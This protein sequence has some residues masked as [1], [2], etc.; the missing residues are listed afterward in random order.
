M[1]KKREERK[2]EKREKKQVRILLV[3][4]ATIFL[5]SISTATAQVI[6]PEPV[7]PQTQWQAPAMHFYPYYAEDPST[8]YGFEPEMCN[9]SG[10]DFIVQIAPD[11]CT[12]APVRSD[13]LEE[14]NVPVFCRLTGIKINP[15]IQVPYIERIDA[16]TEQRSDEIFSI[17][18]HPPKSSLSFMSYQAPN[19]N[20]LEGVPTMTNLGYLVIF[21][22]QQPQE[23]KMPDSVKIEE[24][25]KL[26]Y[27]VART[28]G[29]NQNTIVLK[30]DTNEE[31]QENY[32][33]YSFWDGKGYLKLDSIQN[34]KAKI[35]VYKNTKQLIGSTTLNEGDI[36]KEIKLPGFYC[37]AGVQ[38]RVDE[39]TT[40]KTRARLLV[41]GQED[42]VGEG[43]EILD[44]GCRVNK[45]YPSTTPY[46]GT[47]KISCPKKSA[48][49]ELKPLK[50][51]FKVDGQSDVEKSFGDYILDN[52]KYKYIGYI[53]RNKKQG[54]EGIQSYVIIF[55]QD[56]TNKISAGDKNKIINL[57]SDVIENKKEGSEDKNIDSDIVTEIK[58]ALKN[59]NRF[60]AINVEFKIKSDK[61][62]D[63][64]LDS[65]TGLIDVSYSDSIE[66]EFTEAIEAYDA[67]SES[68][69]LVPTEDGTIYGV[70][71][72]KAAAD[73]AEIFNKKETQAEYLDKIIRD[74]SDVEA[75]VAGTIDDARKDLA[76]LLS[77]DPAKSTAVLPTK[78]GD[79]RF[80]LLAIEQPGEGSQKLIIDVD[81][82]DKSYSLYDTIDDWR[83]EEIKENF[84]KLRCIITN[85]GTEQDKISYG[86]ERTL[87]KGNSFITRDSTLKIIE[88]ELI[89]EVK[90]TVLPFESRRTTE[91]NFT[92]QIGIEKR[93]IQLN[94]EKTNER[95]E[96]LN[97]LISK[98]EGVKNSLGKVINVWKKACLVGGTALWAKNFLQ[99][100]DG[101]SLARKEVMQYYG[102]WC[103]DEQHRISVGADTISG[104]YKA[105]QQDIN[106]DVEKTKE[107]INLAN[108][109]IKEVK[110]KDGVVK[111]KGFL[112]LG[113]A[114]DEERFFEE[115]NILI[116][117]SKYNE[118]RNI[119]IDKDGNQVEVNSV[120]DLQA[121]KEN[122]GTE[123]V[124]DIIHS[125][126]LQKTCQ[127][128]QATV[129]ICEKINIKNY[130]QF[131][132]YKSLIKESNTRNA[133]E[134]LGLPYIPIVR[135]QG[136][137]ID[138]P[139]IQKISELKQQEK[140]G[141][142]KNEFGD[143]EIVWISGEGFNIVAS[144]K[145]VGQGGYIIEKAIPVE[146]RN[147]N[148]VNIKNDLTTEEKTR[149]DNLV[150]SQ[151][152]SIRLVDESKCTNNPIATSSQEIRFWESGEYKGMVALMPIDAARGYYV[153]IKSYSGFEGGLVAYGE[154]S[155]NINT[156][157]IGNV[158]PDKK[159]DFDFSTGLA[160]IG[161]DDCADV[162]SL[163]Q[164]A[165][166]H[167][168]G[169]SNPSAINDKAKKC[170]QEAV[171]QYAQGKREIKTSCGTFKVGKSAT[172]APTS[173]CEDFMSP[174]DCWIMY[175]LCDPVMCPSSRCDLG[176]RYPVD[177]VA[178]TGII[179]S[180]MLC[181]PN[182]ENGKGVLV[183]ICLDGLHAGLENLEVT[184][185]LTR[186]CL[187]ENINTGKMT[188]ICDQIL[189]IYLCD[190]LWQ[191]L[192]PLIKVGLPSLTE[193]LT[194]RGGGEYALFP[195][196]WK[197]SVDS[198]EYFT[199]YYG[200]STFTAFKE[201][202]TAQIGT[203]VC[204]RFMSVAYP[205][206]TK[207]WEEI[208][209]PES[210]T[211]FFA[212]F[213]ELE[214]IAA[215]QAHYKVYYQIYAGQD[216]GVAYRVYLKSPSDPG[217]Y[218]TPERYYVPNA[219]GYLA[220]GE[221]TAASPDF[222][223]PQ[224]YKEVCVDIN[225]QENCG[226]T[227]VTSN[228]AIDELQS[229]YVEQQLEA[230]VTK[231]KDCISGAPTFIPTA[232]LN[233]QSAVQ[234]T[235]EPAIYR[236]GI[237]RICASQ[238][239]GAGVDEDRYKLVGYC[240]NP[241]IGCYLD[242]D[243][244][245]NS[246][247]DL[248]IQEDI[249]T[250][251]ESKEINSLMEIEGL[252]H[253][254]ISRDE[255]TKAED[256]INK[257]GG[258][259]EIVEFL[260]QQVRQDFEKNGKAEARTNE[261]IEIAVKDI[262]SLINSF[263]EISAGCIY[264]SEKARADFNI[265]LLKEFKARL[266]GT[267]AIA[268]GEE[269][270]K[271][272]AEPT[273]EAEVTQPTEE[274]G[275][276]TV[277]P[278]DFYDGIKPCYSPKYHEIVI[279]KPA[280]GGK[281]GE[282]GGGNIRFDLRAIAG[283]EI[284]EK[285]LITPGSGSPTDY[286][287]M[288]I[289]IKHHDTFYSSYYGFFIPKFKVGDFVKEG[290][291]F[292]SVDTA[293][294]FAVYQENP[295]YMRTTKKE[296][297]A[298]NPF[299]YFSD[300]VL[301]QIKQC[302]DDIEE[303]EKYKIISGPFDQW[304]LDINKYYIL[305]SRGCYGYRSLSWVGKDYTDGIDISAPGGAEVYAV[306]SGEVFYIS[307][308]C[309]R[310]DLSS[311]GNCK[312]GNCA[313]N[314]GYGNSVIIKHSDNLFTA[315]NHLSN[316]DVKKGDKINT[317]QKL[318]TVGSTGCSSDNHLDFKVYTSQQE[319]YIYVGDKGKHPLCFFSSE[320]KNKIDYTTSGALTDSKSYVENKNLFGTEDGGCNPS[321]E[322][323]SKFI[324]FE[325]EKTE[326]SKYNS[327]NCENYVGC[328]YDYSWEKC[329]ECPSKCEGETR[330]LGVF[331]FVG[332][333]FTGTPVNANDII[334]KTQDDC[335]NNNCDLPYCLWNEEDEK[336][337][338]LSPQEKLSK[339]IR[340]FSKEID[341][342][343][344]IGGKLYEIKNLISNIDILP[345]EKYEE[346]KVVLESLKQKTIDI[347]NFAEEEK[348][349]SIQYN[350]Y[351]EM[352]DWK[353]KIENALDYISEKETQVILVSSIKGSYDSK[354]KIIENNDASKVCAVFVKGDDWFNDELAGEQ[355]EGKTIQAL[356]AS[357]SATITWYKIEPY[358][359]HYDAGFRADFPT[360][361]GE[362]NYHGYQNTQ[363]SVYWSEGKDTIQYKN[364]PLDKTTWCINVGSNYGVY[365][366]RTEIVASEGTYSSPG[367]PASEENELGGYASIYQNHLNTLIEPSAYNFEEGGIKDS[368]HTIARRSD[369][370]DEHSSYRN[371]YGT[372]TK[373]MQFLEYVD[374]HQGAVWIY[375]ENPWQASN[376]IGMD[377][378]NL[379]TNSI[380]KM[381]E[382]G[383]I[384][385]TFCNDLDK[386]TADYLAQNYGD[387]NKVYY[388]TSEDRKIY[389]SISET[390]VEIPT[391][392]LAISSA[393]E[394]FH[395]GDIFLLARGNTNADKCYHTM[396][397]YEDDGDGILDD[398][399]M[400]VYI[401]RKG[402]TKKAYFKDIEEIT[403]EESVYFRV[404]R[405]NELSN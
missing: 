103:A 283:G 111:S 213:D 246:I 164:G 142:L 208:S 349:Y 175:N 328:W 184:L 376:F 215:S 265:A 83:I 140:L 362:S 145:D 229:L 392:D 8:Q 306:A 80:T 261:A 259:K 380:D 294:T 199:Q 289:T 151:I 53:G 307:E 231:T 318:G 296:V 48:D 85:C 239:P 163:Q 248:G 312:T 251:A 81:G 253:P 75:N 323:C 373:Q 40:P 390:I 17:T 107:A 132:Y 38:L 76:R 368:V 257:K 146:E 388:Y 358:A 20:Q 211:Q 370:L 67:I 50:A 292:A 372:T 290:E 223:A 114:I 171:Q 44:S 127:E 25:L 55:Y 63:H 225:G 143:K 109:F 13:L 71:A 6:L 241:N 160:K 190:F 285:E 27:N 113:K 235:I 182:F 287:E 396:I 299:C 330:G 183:P 100:L 310:C 95:I 347:I 97:K 18:Y 136:A 314:N 291:V 93:A 147:G 84:I 212:T 194:S 39:I 130:D 218:I 9:K 78:N 10:M 230:K 167:V 242:M 98:I 202:S 335:E 196:A 19:Q 250:E 276:L 275:T 209:K 49:L 65:T 206:Q 234:S 400:F 352:L 166:I 45:I 21:L 326:C 311:S 82:E 198:F 41:N 315:Y 385:C 319:L 258:I 357:T 68:Y 340:D 247:K 106:K 23:S 133:A 324:T 173:Q 304:P 295:M 74:Y 30:Q 188:G 28:F 33:K 197:N 165:D 219:Y 200:K 94:P 138:V 205:T 99:G 371:K 377:C 5:A 398:E 128:E 369:Y 367:K 286:K 42:L 102:E 309:E 266:F 364:I 92:I 179:G 104:C 172:A 131:S 237:V 268:R 126:Q 238:D 379:V 153:G 344:V 77:V 348:I 329:K 62:A 281:V 186:D 189:S 12:P 391:T 233:L 303:C 178:S 4:L 195:E 399:D 378:P 169:A 226:F 317:K 256:E 148:F 222:I 320:I 270:I 2:E 356:A 51:T 381:A 264:D 35:S 88:I 72:L 91:A 3:L 141:N 139:S 120:L 366:Y 341:K 157:T 101:T 227:Q 112:G 308:N 363:S 58:T 297:Q 216:Q 274:K 66:Q 333:L 11:A 224:G 137:T 331:E 280:K 334:F 228:F 325:Q 221:Y 249:A 7:L 96:D 279:S 273:T 401:G 110:S 210:P 124:K 386:I 193:S 278:V 346:F 90:V 154:I 327:N 382:R 389:Q 254:D 240:D 245:E 203:E 118:L 393:P 86:T 353:T 336:C 244:V 204:K 207:F 395:I 176:G 16:R 159:I 343:F 177:N 152:N 181:W 394:K 332:G 24:T 338:T 305:G 269:E 73:L 260:E 29:I 403:Q 168:S 316:I 402:L 57:I 293:L 117:S 46:T 135:V 255:L 271:Q 345:R 187:Q 89:K 298:V 288:I 122:L 158:G 70:K 123:D 252:Q 201:R 217:Y 26:T 351:K 32:K 365:R 232:S 243:S 60:S 185:K 220:A 161:S 150:Y 116:K 322:Y 360:I 405:I 37:G 156:Y 384:T 69:S 267:E 105:K 134:E 22:R 64:Q 56:S 282:V 354:N 339:M 263:D 387:Y 1:N 129:V 174:E 47:V 34:D 397:L 149:F 192:D 272:Q 125:L 162:I 301:N 14:Q 61:I 350:Q 321:A 170:I 108:D 404:A 277:W 191:N 180:L 36:S 119:I 355:V 374:A 361:E 313:C 302:K 144:V 337:I 300:S 155:G 54:V 284:I 383:Y 262:N 79:Y 43:E 15:L 214:A 59:Y 342:H 52:G 375:G 121:L 359:N 115:A 31:W 87:N 236:K